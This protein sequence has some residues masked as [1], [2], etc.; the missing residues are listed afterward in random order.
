VTAG[1]RR[2]RPR[3]GEPAFPEDEV[4]ALLVYG[5]AAVHAMTGM[6][7]Q[8]YPSSREIASRFGVSHTTI[9]D[10]AKRKN[11]LR[12][13]QELTA[14]VRAKADQQLAEVRAKAVVVTNEDFGNLIS[15]AFVAFAENLREKKIRFDSVRDLSEL[16]RM[17]QAF[18]T[19]TAGDAAAVGGL[20]L[21]ALQSK[22][23][24]ALADRAPPEARGEVLYPANPP[25]TPLD[26]APREGTGQRA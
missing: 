5:E 22:H 6:P 2:G 1:P 11:C 16:F 13:R 18:N 4:D 26:E 10:Y 19:R 15:E 17:H 24:E 9:A 14:R 3:G 12:R 25:A 21:E 20:S 23:R 8:R 7:C